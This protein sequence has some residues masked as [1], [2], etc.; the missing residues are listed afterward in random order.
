[1]L[2]DPNVGLSSGLSANY[3][4]LSEFVPSEGNEKKRICLAIRGLWAGF[5]RPE[6]SSFQTVEKLQPP[7]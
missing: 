2:V 3:E 1:M 6:L 4:M 5:A 7:R